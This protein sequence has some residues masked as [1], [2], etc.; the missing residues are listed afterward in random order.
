VTTSPILTFVRLPAAMPIRKIAL[1]L[2]LLMI[3]SAASAA[4]VFPASP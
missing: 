1:G 2:H 4:A 3:L